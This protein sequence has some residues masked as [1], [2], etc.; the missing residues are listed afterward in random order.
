MRH[1]YILLGIDQIVG[2]G[3]IDSLAFLQDVFL[4]F[5]TDVDVVVLPPL[6]RLEVVG[7]AVVVATVGPA[8]VDE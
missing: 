1:Q 3:G 2:T 7:V 6:L 8:F 4:D 5:L